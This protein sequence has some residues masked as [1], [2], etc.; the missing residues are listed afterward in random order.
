VTVHVAITSSKA[1]AK[2]A[3]MLVFYSA[4]KVHCAS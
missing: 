1:R 2:G 4:C 3:F